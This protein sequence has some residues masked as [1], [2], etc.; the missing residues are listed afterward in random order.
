MG[1]R[2]MVGAEVLAV[3]C[4]FWLTVTGL[5]GGLNMLSLVAK[6]TR[7]PRASEGPARRRLR[8]HVGAFVEDT[9]RWAAFL[10][11]FFG[12]YVGTCEAMEALAVRLEHTHTHSSSNSTKVNSDR[13][14]TAA[15][16]ADAAAVAR[17]VRRWK[18]LASVCAS[19]PALLLVPE[20]HSLTLYL[21]CR[22][23]LL[24]GRCALKRPSLHPWVRR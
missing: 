16:S 20:N 21:L 7:P 3:W 18:V 17:G 1:G 15:V 13:E 10:G 5:K 14:H 11:L 23:S 2:E 24:L 8:K 6:L 22:S 9:A 19:S 4:L 12:G